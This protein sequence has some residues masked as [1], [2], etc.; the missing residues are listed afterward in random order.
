MAKHRCE[1]CGDNFPRLT[2]YMIHYHREH[3]GKVDLR[4]T[5]SCWSCAGQIHP[6]ANQCG[7]CGWVRVDQHKY[8]TQKVE[9][10]K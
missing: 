9:V 2:D 5:V 4:R 1:Y 6:D 10:A 7:N 8:G 3:E